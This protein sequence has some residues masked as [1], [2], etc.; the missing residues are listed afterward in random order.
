MKKRLLLIS[1]AVATL[2]CSTIVEAYNHDGKYHGRQSFRKHYQQ[3]RDY[4]PQ[5]PQ[6][7]HSPVH[8]NVTSGVLGSVL[9]YEI[10]KDDA[11]TAGVDS[12][13]NSYLEIENL[14]KR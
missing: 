14:K 8:E 9:G 5:R 2:L 12:T 10:A 4:Y 11:V 1:L 7:L 3:P 6:Y 13:G